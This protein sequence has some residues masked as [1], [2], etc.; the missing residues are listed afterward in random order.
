[1]VE[2][3]LSGMA[4]LL[5]LENS[6]KCTLVH[7]ISHV[8]LKWACEK[9]KG[10]VPLLDKPN[11]FKCDSVYENVKVNTHCCVNYSVAEFSTVLIR[12]SFLFSSGNLNIPFT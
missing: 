7:M 6:G 4:K 10:K 8:Y 5:N 1:M 3:C 12:L 9:K 2:I 11:H